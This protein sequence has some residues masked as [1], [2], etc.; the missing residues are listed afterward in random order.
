MNN[1]ELLLEASSYHALFD[2]LIDGI[3]VFSDNNQ[4]LFKNRV[5][6]TFSMDFKASLIDEAA[7]GA[8]PH[9]SVFWRADKLIKKIGLESGYAYMISP[10]RVESS[11]AEVTLKKLTDALEHS[12]NI[13][14]AAA[15]AIYQCLSWR[16]VAITRFRTPKR[17]EVLSFWDTNKKLDEYEY[18]LV[19]TP[20]EMVV[21]TNKFTLFSDVLSAFPNYQALHQM[22]VKTY[23]GLVY[24]GPDN[25]PLGHVMAMHDH[26]DVDFALAEEV[27]NIATLALSSHFQ[28][29]KATVKL[30]EAQQQVK[31][32][33]LTGIGNRHAYADALAKVETEFNAN[34]DGDWTIAI[35]D[36]DHLKPLNDNVGHNA[37]DNFIKLMAVELSKIGRQS[38]IAFR[39]GGDEFAI[40]FTQSSNVFVSSLLER[41]NKA[42]ERV[43]LAMRFPVGA[44]VGLALLS[45]V[46]GNI[47]AWT[48]LADERMYKNKKANKVSL[49]AS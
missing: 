39:I 2:H 8:S 13:Y 42:L 15:E 10:P 45:E 1:Q 4:V 33:S 26:R 29:H 12:E 3:I 11:I 35:V 7:R 34:Q 14:V 5:F 44:S 49:Q 32:D 27:I 17:L 38:D 28:L 16:W 46:D 6:E 30:K 21:D 43:R 18:D 37:G 19:G 48:A 23:A 40:I 22:G 20:C 24:R 41:F 9:T 36:L 47:D 25:Q 31:I